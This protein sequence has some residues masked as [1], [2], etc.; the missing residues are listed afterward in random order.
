MPHSTPRSGPLPVPDGY[1]GVPLRLAEAATLALVGPGSHVDV[2][3]VGDDGRATPIA[4]AAL[5]LG[6][7]DTDDDSSAGLLVALTPAEADR[8]VSRPGHGFAVLLR[9]D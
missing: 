6:T 2:L 5:V 3:R 7:T 4:S 9:P 8:A 1:V